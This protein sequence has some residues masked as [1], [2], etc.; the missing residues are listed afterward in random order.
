M[1]RTAILALA[2]LLVFCC[3]SSAHAAVPPSDP[4]APL[5]L[6]SYRAELQAWSQELESLQEH[7]EDA[8]KFR[9]SLPPK[10]F[11]NEGTQ[12][13][14]VSHS[15]LNSALMEFTAAKPERRAELVRQIQGRLAAQ[16]QQAEEFRATAF[17]SPSSRQKLAEIL[18]QREFR[19]VHGPSAWDVWKQRLINRIFHWLDR[20]F[21]AVPHSSRGGEIV[22]WIVIAVALCVVAIW[23]KRT[24]THRPVDWPREPVPFA[25]SAKHWRKWLAEAR[26]AA[27]QGR[28]RDAIHLAYWAAISQLEQAGAWIPDRARTPR[29]YLRLL[30]NPSEKR[31]ILETLTSRFEVTWYG[32]HDAVSDDFADTL[33]QLEK[34]GCR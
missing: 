25:P 29:E 32:Y 8:P 10:S 5:S 11:V 12:T 18:S 4:T 28:W 14:E 3:H 1:K 7:P 15:W 31:S 30:P 34:L 24:A 13:L 22:V 19:R 27:Q 21:S 9:A 23:L 26:D 6:E 17:Y 20:I 2:P 16:R 33:V